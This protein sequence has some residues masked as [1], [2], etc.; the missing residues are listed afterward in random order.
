LKLLHRR[1]EHLQDLFQ[2]AR[3]EIAKLAGDEARFTQFL[4]GVIVQA[5]L[6]LTEPAATVHTR[7]KDIEIAQRAVESAKAQYTELTGEGVEVEVEGSL[8]DD[9]CVL[10]RATSACLADC[11]AAQAVSYWS[12]ARSV[13]R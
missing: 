4:E 3:G 5:L 10:T 13:S 1:E 7:E 6:Q 12:R 2:I 11:P 8:G 9:M